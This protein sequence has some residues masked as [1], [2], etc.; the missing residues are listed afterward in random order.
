M[1]CRNRFYHVWP[2]SSTYNDM[3]SLKEI[4]GTPVTNKS[5]SWISKNRTLENQRTPS[6]HMLMGECVV[7][8]IIIIPKSKNSS[9]SLFFFSKNSKNIILDYSNWGDKLI[10][11][12]KEKNIKYF[13]YSCHSPLW[14][15]E[16]F[17]SKSKI[18]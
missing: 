4:W 1:Q 18:F 12:Y 5:L 7:Y 13:S 3:R 10:C 9:R 15:I 8:A 17:Y 14:N 16:V 11:E 6:A 2:S